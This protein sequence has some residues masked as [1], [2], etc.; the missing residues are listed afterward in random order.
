MYPRRTFS[1]GLGYTLFKVAKIVSKSAR[2]QSWLCLFK[3]KERLCRDPDQGWQIRTSD[4]ELVCVGTS[5]G[6]VS[7]YFSRMWLRF[8]RNDSSTSTPSATNLS[9]RALTDTGSFR[10]SNMKNAILFSQ[11]RISYL[12]QLSWSLETFRFYDEDDC[13]NEIFSITSSSSASVSVIRAGKRDSRSLFTTGFSEKVVVTETSYQML[14][15]LSFSRS[16]EG[17]TSFN[18]K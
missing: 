13:E 8:C 15:N 1:F 3:Y 16:G 5:N 18:K 11:C 17:L 10:A 7:E 12:G 2:S 4:G 6:T 9:Y 14:T